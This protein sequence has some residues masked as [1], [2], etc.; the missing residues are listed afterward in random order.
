M[1]AAHDPL[2]SSRLFS[3]MTPLELGAIEA[4]LE[5]R[6]L[7]PQEVL[8]REGEV[9]SD[10]YIV[11]TG[12]MGS[13]VTQADGSRRELYEFLAGDQFGEMA[14]IET[15]PRSATTYAKGNTEL[16]VLAAI[17]FYR[18]VWEHPV[19]GV[20]LMTSLIGVM[21]QWLEEASGF[22][23]GMVRWGEAARRRSITDDLSGLFN[24]RFLDDA[25]R[26]R[27]SRGSPETRRSSLIMIDIDRFREINAEFGSAAGDAVIAN[28]GAA[29]G[30]AV[31]EPGIAAR[32]S[33]DEFAVF[34]PGVGMHEAALLGGS[35]RL[36]AE[37]LY[38]EFRSGEGK[39]PIRL[40]VTISLG[41][42]SSDN[43]ADELVANADKALYAAKE[44]G[45]NCVECFTPTQDKGEP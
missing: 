19:I 2:A 18:L 27:F 40:A 36:V 8:F 1:S 12:I 17:D 38:L 6:T 42:A 25:L 7:A 15:A 37:G 33:G 28:I 13:F 21:T 10:L 45:R 39:E 20:K 3:A 5:R 35:L 43:G 30:R 11:R 9:G 44:N 4:F 26:L 24:R 32:L 16:A 41:V 22:L 31:G 14:V 34:L 29:F 23:G